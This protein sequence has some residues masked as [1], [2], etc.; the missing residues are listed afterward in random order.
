MDSSNLDNFK[1]IMLCPAMV[2]GISSRRQELYK[3]ATNDT[4]DIMWGRYVL[5]PKFLHQELQKILELSETLTYLRSSQRTCLSND[6]AC[7]PL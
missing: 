5:F 4:T 1:N 7:Q 6:F 2:G 3:E